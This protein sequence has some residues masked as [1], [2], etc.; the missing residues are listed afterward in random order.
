MPSCRFLPVLAKTSTLAVDVAPSGLSLD[1]TL[2]YTIRLDNKSLQALF[3]VVVRDDLPPQ[4]KYVP[5][6]T[7]L[8]Q[9]NQGTVTSN[10]MTDN[11]TGTP[12]P[13]DGI[14]YSL[15]TVPAGGG[16]LFRFRARIDASGCITNTAYADHLRVTD[17]VCLDTPMTIRGGVGGPD[18]T[19]HDGEK[20]SVSR[21]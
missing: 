11:V 2:E 4:V 6:S 7:C 14:G 18:G 10:S 8:I 5:G 13:L 9:T 16:A 21:T 15:L 3:D 19:P 12:F 20:P 17:V 1:D